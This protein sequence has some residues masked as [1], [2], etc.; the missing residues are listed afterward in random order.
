MAP[1]PNEYFVAGYT[2][3]QPFDTLTWRPAAAKARAAD[4]RRTLYW[5]PSVFVD[6]KNHSI[7]LTFANNALGGPIRIVVEGMDEDGNPIH[8]EKI[9]SQ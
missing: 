7:P 6:G 8:L 9:I 2:Q 1:D 4:L 3:S 5:N